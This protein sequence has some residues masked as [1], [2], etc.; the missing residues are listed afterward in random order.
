MQELNRK[1]K[2]ELLKE[3]VF[4]G[5]LSHLG[6]NKFA[7]SSTLEQNQPWSSGRV[8]MR[9]CLL[10]GMSQLQLGLGPR[11]TVDLSMSDLC[12]RDMCKISCE[13]IIRKVRRDSRSPNAASKGLY[14]RKNTLWQLAS[15]S[16]RL[17]FVLWEGSAMY[18]LRVISGGNFR[19][20]WAPFCQPG[21]GRTSVKSECS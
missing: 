5:T 6:Q 21:R 12:L 14:Q 8:D 4:A 9:S 11:Q 13:E 15:N 1:G 20:L 2:L 16:V 10:H 3:C 19:S 17:T 18:R 7:L